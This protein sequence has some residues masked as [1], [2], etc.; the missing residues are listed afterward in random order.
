MR[1][2]ALF[3]LATG[4]ATPAA[5]SCEGRTVDVETVLNGPLCVPDHPQRIVTLD[6]TFNLTMA[7]EL[8][9]PVVGA[10][11]FGVED[12][13]LL[14]VAKAAGVTDI[15]SAGEP[16]I[17]SIVALQ[18]DLILG[19]AARADNSGQ[20]AGLEDVLCNHCGGNRRGRQGERCIRDL[21]APR[22]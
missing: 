10:P 12:P 2:I 8:G 18:P 6:A 14:A 7:L 20:L 11:L 4:L 13:K 22:H 19:D 17:E 9:L 1:L 16:S 21:R 15:G 5:A 3:L